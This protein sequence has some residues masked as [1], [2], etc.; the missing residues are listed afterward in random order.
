MIKRTTNRER[1]VIDR[2][3]DRMI[4]DM[5][6]VFNDVVEES[7][8]AFIAEVARHIRIDTGMSIASLYPLAVEVNFDNILAAQLRGK[9]PTRVQY[10]KPKDP[11]FS[12]GYGRIK[13]W[14]LGEELGGSPR[15]YSL[16]F[17]MPSK[18]VAHFHFKIVVLQY[19]LHES[20]LAINSTTPW[21]SLTKGREALVNYWNQNADKRLG[22]RIRI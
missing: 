20:G 17:G 18:P 19:Y 12:E 13:W 3:F 1:V 5:F 22:Q 2:K 6:E 8:G 4:R 14:K 7:I 15:A 9:G 10:Y 11:R 16:E 21:D